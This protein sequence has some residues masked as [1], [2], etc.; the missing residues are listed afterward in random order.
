MSTSN[1]WSIS[2]NNLN[3]YNLDK[4]N[5]FFHVEYSSASEPTYKNIGEQFLDQYYYSYDNNWG[6]L[7][8][9]YLEESIFTFQDEEYV[10]IHKIRNK[11]NSLELNNP[12]HII[13]SFNIQPVE[14]KKVSIMVTGSLRNTIYAS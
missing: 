6:Y 14:E 11:Y 7:Y 4:N 1:W 9:Y 8:N 3:N 10:G 5:F 2:T 12:E 13:H